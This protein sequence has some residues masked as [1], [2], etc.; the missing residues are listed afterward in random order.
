MTPP[1][2]LGRRRQAA[3]TGE[4][5]GVEVHMCP[6]ICKCKVPSCPNA[7]I[8]PRHLLHYHIKHNFVHK[9]VALELNVVAW[10]GIKGS[11]PIH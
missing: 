9:Q 1:N 4:V 11:L 5:A 10:G 7:F 3:K 8:S 6:G 2:V